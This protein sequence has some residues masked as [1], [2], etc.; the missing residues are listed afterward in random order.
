MQELVRKRTLGRDPEA[1]VLEDAL[2]L[3]FLETQLDEF[4]ARTDEEKVLDVIRKT[5]GKMSERGLALASEL[6]LAARAQSLLGRA[7]SS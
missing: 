4:A 6:P 3:V 5:A 2:C 7:L 1:Q